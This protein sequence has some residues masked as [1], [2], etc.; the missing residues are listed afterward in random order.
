MHDRHGKAGQTVVNTEIE[1]GGGFPRRAIRDEDGTFA[2]LDGMV[3]VRSAFQPIFRHFEER[4]YPVAF[5]ALARPFRGETPLLPDAYLSQVPAADLP[6]VD[7]LIRQIH[8]LNACHLPHNARRL[9]LNFHPAGLGSPADFTADLDALGSDLRR[10]GISPRDVVCEFTEQRER[11]AEDLKFFVYALRAR[12]FLIAVDDFGVAF[13]DPTRIAR[14]TPDIVKLDGAVVRRLLPVEEGFDELRRLVDGFRAE[15]IRCVL[16]GIE[17]WQQVELARRTGAHFLQ[18]YALAGPQAVPGHFEPLMQA[19]RDG[20][21]DEL[22]K[23][24]R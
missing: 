15:G 6:G 1:Q 2:A 7:A 4:L 12:G 3:L 10:A 11:S 16:E 8:V 23:A 22:V 14:L 19:Y 18:G 21:E 17:N 20:T 24:L 13:S 9:F 5:E